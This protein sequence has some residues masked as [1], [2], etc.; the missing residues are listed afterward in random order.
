MHCRACGYEWSGE[1]TTCPACGAAVNEGIVGTGEEIYRLGVLAEKGAKKNTAARHYA[2]AADLG[3]PL[4]AW[5]VCRCLDR[6]EDPEL[7]EFWLLTAAERDPI[8]AKAYADYLKRMGDG[9]GTLRYLHHA[10]SLGSDEA[11]RRLAFY[12]LRHRNRPVARYYLSRAH[13]HPFAFLLKLFVG[14]GPA[15]APEMPV[16][17]DNTVEMYKLGAYAAAHGLPHIA[18]FYYERAADAAYLPAVERVA[19]M[20]MRGQ[21]VT[22]DVRHVAKYLGILGAAG[23]T[24]AYLR[25]ADYYETGVLDGAPNAVAATE[26]YR[27]AA[28][29]GDVDG[30]VALGDRCADGIGTA[31]DLCAALRL[32]D[33]AAAGGSNEG[34]ERADA[35]RRRAEADHRAGL[36]AR[37]SDPAAAYAAFT[38]AAETG[39][40]EALCAV[41][42]ARIAG[43]GCTE[44]HAGAVDAYLRA[45]EAGS[46]RALYRLGCLYL[47]N[48]AVRFDARLARA[49]LEG[50]KRGGITAA[51]A[52]LTELEN[53]R[54][55]HLAS[56]LYAVS[57]VVYHRGDHAAAVRF[58]YEAAKLGH[59]RATYLLGC[60]YDCGDALPKDA[61]RAG[62]LY[63]RA[64]LLGFDGKESGFYGKYLRGLRGGK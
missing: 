12:Y 23:R 2:A 25:L 57:C 18:F 36:E 28:E 49:C 51:D 62:V 59:A 13:G 8:A 20:Y 35:L 42:D 7:Y 5:G 32:Y 38:R 19:E 46:H 58:R 27:L 60:M 39:H 21:G 17:P 10:A 44:D 47:Y 55:K 16:A 43:V 61:A 40:A 41:G 9:M 48:Y 4:A 1:E 15:Y 30:M 29:A 11:R 56:K 26:T 53:R 31:R 24:D 22:R 50:A 3:V 64:K 52:K 63:A 37:E 34:R 33:R 45:A 6:G 14:R 54:K